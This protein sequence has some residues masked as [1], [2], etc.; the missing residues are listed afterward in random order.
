M[1]PPRQAG[2]AAIVLLAFLGSLLGGFFLVFNVGQLVTDQVRLVTAADAAAYSAAVWEARSLN[3]QATLNRAIVANEVAIAQFVSLRSW[4]AHVDRGIDNAATVASWV[5]PLGRALQ[6]LARGWDAVDR[7]LQTTLPPLESAL[8]AWN[9]DALV[10]AQDLAHQQALVGAADLVAEVARANEPRA[11]VGEGTRVLQV[12]N[13]S[14][15]Q[16][17]LTSRNRRGGSDLRRYRDLLHA[18]RDGFSARRA[19][20][21]LPSNP[22]LS[23]PR[24]GG[25]ELLGE[26]AW[27]AVDTWSLHI[28]YLLGS[29]EVPFAWG[30][31]EQRERPVAQRGQHGGSRRDNPRATSLAE[32]GLV[33]SAGYSGIP[34]IRDIIRPARR[35]DLRLTYGV[36]LRLPRPRVV[37]I[38]SLLLPSGLDAGAGP[39]GAGLQLPADALHAQATAEVFFARPLAR[40]DGRREFPS[41]FNPYW[42]VRPVPVSATDRQLTAPTRGVAVDP[43]AVLP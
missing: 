2:Q 28:D 31:A 23:A 22:L 11:E 30:A 18:S 9:V 26:Q 17:G 20:D 33:A 14:G 43:F 10:R 34:E 36:S 16:S 35:D 27:R 39:V 15:W 41:L 38:E 3:F 25:T 37:S 29:R 8:S 42:Q 40:A 7:S 19:F 5:P 24:R 6:V 13:A 12:R 4:S 1:L 32:R 21:P